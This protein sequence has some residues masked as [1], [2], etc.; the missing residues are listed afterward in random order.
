MT[1]APA[2]FLARWSRSRRVSARRGGGGR[3][4]P[5]Y[6]LLMARLAERLPNGDTSLPGAYRGI[7]VL[8][9]RSAGMP[10]RWVTACLTRVQGTCAEVVTRGDADRA[11]LRR[12]S[13]AGVAFSPAR[14]RPT[15]GRGRQMPT[16]VDVEVTNRCN[17]KCHFCPRDRTPHQGLM[18]PEVFAKALE[19]AVEYRGRI[20]DLPNP[21]LHVSLCGLG[22]PLL[23]RNVVDYVRLARAE[24]FFVKM[25]SNASLLDERRS[26]ALLEAGLQQILINVGEEGDDYEAVYH[27]P[28]ER[29][30][31]NVLRFNEM[32][33]GA[34]EV[35]M[36]IVDHR[37]NPDHVARMTKYWSDRGIPQALTYQI[38]NRGGSLFVEHMQYGT[39]PEQAAALARLEGKLGG[40]VCPA[41]FGRSRPP[42]AASSTS[43]SW[44]WPRPSSI[45]SSPATSCAARATSTRSTA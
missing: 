19:R 32:S 37:G 23:N 13:S 20:A 9:T 15:R 22:E 5:W 24:G 26:A 34:C 42:W 45:S 10:T 39:Y 21:E 31:Q 3:H 41:P 38:M 36:V 17:A 8:G 28:F 18:S 14:R 30:L 44:T 40:A 25:S 6:C 16:N 2:Q 29:T 11:I 7:V 35:T 4:P 27:L 43:P 12:G 33:A 1:K